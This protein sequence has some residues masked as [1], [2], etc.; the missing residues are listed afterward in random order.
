MKM[1][2]CKCDVCREDIKLS[3]DENTLKLNSASYDI[4]PECYNNL[5]EL[6]TNIIDMRKKY[7]YKGEI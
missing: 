3:N 2:K 6:I 7:I 4:C 1:I 5:C